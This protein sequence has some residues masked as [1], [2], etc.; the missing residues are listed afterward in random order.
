MNGNGA[1][2]T[3]AVRV[4]N[5]LTAG[6]EKRILMWMAQR[7]PAAIGPDH[8][9][10]LA[11]ACQILAG[12]GYALSAKNGHFLWLVNVF[13][14]F[15]WLGDSLD[16]TLAR[17]RNRQRPRYGFYVDHISDTF[18]AFALMAGLGLSGLLDW[19]IAAG[20]LVCFYGLSIESYLATYTTGRFQL[21]HGMFGPTEIRIL[22]AVGNAVVISRPHVELAGRAFRLFDFG[23]LLAIFGMAA[24]LVSAAVRQT[25]LLYREETLP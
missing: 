24:M 6:I 15:N 23:G 20:M 4:H 21:S 13:L 5:A 1:G 2:F 3:N 18:G 7:T 11:L 14:A 17:V 16:G 22:L 12:A 9:T 19:K 8:L 10:A 25:M